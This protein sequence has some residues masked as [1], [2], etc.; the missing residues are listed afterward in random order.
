MFQSATQQLTKR[1]STEKSLSDVVN[2][3]VTE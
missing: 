2:A 1:V 3:M